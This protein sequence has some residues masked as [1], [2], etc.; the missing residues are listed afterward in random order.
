MSPRLFLVV[1]LVT[2]L[3]ATPPVEPGPVL[4]ATAEAAWLPLLSRLGAPRPLF[5]SFEEERWFSVRK[6]PVVLRGEMRLEPSRGLSLFYREPEEKLVVLD[7]KGALL[8]DRRG[9]RTLPPDPRGEGLEQ[10][11][12]PAL[13]FDLAEIRRRFVVH[14]AR[15]G[16]DWR[17]DLVPKAQPTR[18]SLG[19]LVI[20]GTG[21]VV[22]RLEFRRSPTQ[23]VTIKILATQDPAAFS[24]GDLQRFFR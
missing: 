19:N 22:T 15:D 16:A 5:S 3:R 1:L 12:L 7:A 9:T 13:R 18:R 4:D 8:R 11:L 24:A 21:D 17:L 10:A 14:A 2:A 23:R 6:A 20:Q